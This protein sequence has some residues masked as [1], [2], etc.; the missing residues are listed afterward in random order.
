ML[1]LFDIDDT[2]IDHS[3]ASRSASIT[4]HGMIDSVH[5]VDEFVRS[6]AASLDRHYGRYL[7][8]EIG[9]D[10][11]R[12]ARV[13]D[14]VEST[15]TDEEADAVFARYLAAYEGAWAL[16]PD[17]LPCLD[18]LSSCRLGIISNGHS[19]QQ[20]KKLAPALHTGLSSS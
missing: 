11:Q 6:W 5:P 8:G 18:R 9:F 13:R 3:A 4:L 12:R 1:V 16:F 15:L 10:E 20:R 2:L 7:K 14:V 17:V 19:T